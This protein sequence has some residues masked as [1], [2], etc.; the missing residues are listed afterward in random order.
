MV[1]SSK[2]RTSSRHQRLAQR[3]IHDREDDV[4][5]K[6]EMEKMMITMI[7]DFFVEEG[8]GGEKMIKEAIKK[9]IEDVRK[10]MGDVGLQRQQM[11]EDLERKR[12]ER[13]GFGSKQ[14]LQLAMPMLEKKIRV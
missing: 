13:G 4:V 1:G 14:E 9:A 5:D 11:E 2:G 10:D 12:S 6:E 8:G 7:S 3:N